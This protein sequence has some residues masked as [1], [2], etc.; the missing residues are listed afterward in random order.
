MSIDRER[1][2]EI[3]EKILNNSRATKRIRHIKNRVFPTHTI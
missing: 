3:I 2:E 1:I